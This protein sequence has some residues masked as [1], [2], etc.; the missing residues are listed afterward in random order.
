MDKHLC[1][2]RTPKSSKCSSTWFP[3]PIRKWPLLSFCPHTLSF[4]HG[5][6]KSS[7]NHLQIPEWPMLFPASRILLSLCGW[8]ANH[9]LVIP[10]P[11]CTLS[12]G[13]ITLTQKPSWAPTSLGSIFIGSLC[14]YTYVEIIFYFSII[15]IRMDYLKV[16]FLWNLTHCSVLL[17]KFLELKDCVQH[18]CLLYPVSSTLGCHQLQDWIHYFMYY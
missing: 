9:R 18:A 1:F 6:S 8:Q 15:L 7:L 13:N 10:L 5:Y 12:L 16:R 2:S 11:Y 14:S 4:F 3:R 17:T